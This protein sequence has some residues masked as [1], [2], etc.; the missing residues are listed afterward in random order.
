[1]RAAKRLPRLPRTGGVYVLL[2][3]DELD[4]ER[5]KF[6]QRQGEALGG[7]SEPIKRHTTIASNCRL[8]TVSISLLSSG[9]ESFAPDWPT[10]TYSRTRSNPRA[11]Q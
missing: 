5:P 1:M 3:A 2:V 7:T 9:R 11:E 10:S 8:R 4:A 6:L